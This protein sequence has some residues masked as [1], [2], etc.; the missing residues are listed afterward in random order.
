VISVEAFNGQVP[1]GF[2]LRL[3]VDSQTGPVV[4]TSGPAW[5]YYRS[6]PESW[7]ARSAAKGEP[8]IALTTPQEATYAGS[9]GQWPE[10]GR[11]RLVTGTRPPES[12][13]LSNTVAIQVDWRQLSVMRF[14]PDH[15]VGAQYCTLFSPQNFNWT[16]AQAVPLVGFYHSWNP[17][18]LRQHLI[19]L[20]ESGVDFLLVD[21]SNQ[22]WDRKHWDERTWTEAGQAGMRRL[23]YFDSGEV[24]DYAGFF[25]ADGQMPYNGWS[26][27]W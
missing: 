24:G 23:L 6:K 3:E 1:A 7:P 17:D 10:T 18:V 13:V 27:P 15:L 21:W 9:M 19:W 12:A 25:T 14:D 11:G 2:I 26:L 5:E 16:T 4:V 8:V 20:V 22:L